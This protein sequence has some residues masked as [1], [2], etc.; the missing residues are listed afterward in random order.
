MEL[1]GTLWNYMELY[2][3]LWNFWNF[4]ELY[5]TS[6]HF[7]ALKGTLWNFMELLANPFYIRVSRC[8]ILLTGGM[9]L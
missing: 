2:G 5:G 4:M 1:Y 7:M 6:R 9:F 8:R 3:T